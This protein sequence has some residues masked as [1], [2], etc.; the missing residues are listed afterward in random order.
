LINTRCRNQTTRSEARSNL[1]YRPYLPGEV[2]LR[3]AFSGQ[4]PN[5][6]HNLSALNGA[7]VSLGFCYGGF[8]STAGYVPGNEAQD[9]KI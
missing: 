6:L 7:M 9:P 1:V 3:G 2:A 8:S 5:H 4:H